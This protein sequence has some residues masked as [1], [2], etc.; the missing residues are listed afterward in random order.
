LPIAKDITTAS[1]AAAARGRNAVECLVAADSDIELLDRA[2]CATLDGTRNCKN[3]APKA[4]RRR[5]T[6]CNNQ[7]VGSA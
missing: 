3:V 2:R 4:T 5:G 7:A 1:L 6:P